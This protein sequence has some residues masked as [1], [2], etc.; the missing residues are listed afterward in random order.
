MRRF[1]SF[2]VVMLV[3]GAF[4]AVAQEAGSKATSSKSV[5]RLNRAPVNKEVLQVKL[6]RPFES[7]LPNGLIVVVLERHKLP[8]IAATLWVKAG[9]LQDPKDMPGV[10]EFHA[11]MMREGTATQNSSQIA[12]ATDAIGAALSTSA[13]Y[14][15]AF[16]SVSISGLKE[17]AG[18]MFSVMADVAL[19]PIFP[20]EELE[21][22]RARKLAQLQQQRSQ[23][24]FLAQEKFRSVL[25]GDF[26]AAVISA[27]PESTRAIKVEDLRKFHDAWFAPNN[28]ILGIVGDVAPEEGMRLATQYFGG[29]QQKAVPAQSLPP[30]PA[31]QPRKVYLIQRPGS[32]QT[33][34]VAGNLTLKRTDPDY[35]PLTV[36]N[37]ILGGGAAARLFIELREEKGY[38]YGSYSQFTADIYPGPFQA[39]SEQRNNVSKGA[40]DALLA[41]LRKMRDEPVP[42]AELEDDKRSL[43]AAF[44]LSLEN[45]ANLLSRWLTVKYY[46]LPQDYWDTFPGKIS[47]VTAANVQQISRRYI[48]M[49]HLQV[50][51][52]GDGGQPAEEQAGGKTIRD[53]LG[54]GDYG[55][56][57]VFSAE[58]KPVPGGGAPKQ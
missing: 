15:Q 11:A 39:T 57:Q 38:T 13:S 55:P 34:L 23:P 25:Y 30:L 52:V 31:P 48:D 58:G 27:S 10:A 22:F 21:K 51:V 18:K 47:A 49:D 8:T 5:Q 7:R 28:A 37:R 6:P 46:G 40:L 4:T 20:A 17:T 35:I 29:W 16:T 9:A 43:V 1:V 56:L 12:E 54:G 45:P 44:A 33:N 42:S 26:P 53:V 14:G 36:A 19:N 2:F 3:L 41:E 32:V 24:G 50:V